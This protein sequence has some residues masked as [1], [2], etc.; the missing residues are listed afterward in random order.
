MS[1]EKLDD[2]RLDPCI[3]EISKDSTFYY[4][5]DMDGAPLE[6]PIAGNRL[7]KFFPR[8]SLDEGQEQLQEMIRVRAE[9]DVEISEEGQ[10]E[11]DH[12]DLKDE[13]DREGE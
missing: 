4:L 1:K 9:E 3:R 8:T 2:Y 10:E 6:K 11:D 5:E 13:D 7:K 12:E